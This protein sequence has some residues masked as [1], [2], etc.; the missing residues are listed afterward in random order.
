[1]SKDANPPEL[2]VMFKPE[3]EISLNAQFEL[4]SAKLSRAKLRPLTKI[5]QRKELRLEPIFKAQKPVIEMAESAQ[6][7]FSELKFDPKSFISVQSDEDLQAIAA[8]LREQDAVEAA[9]VKPAA[10]LADAKDWATPDF[11]ANQGYL[12]PA[13]QGIDAHF[14]WRMAGGRGEGIE[15]CDVEQGF[16][17][18]HEDLQRNFGGLIGGNNR[19]SS[20]DHGTA[21]LGV[22]GADDNGKGVTGICHNAKIKAISHNG[23]GTAQAIIDAAD[24][25]KAGDIILIEVH[26]P[27][28]AHNPENGSQDAFI[29]IEWWPD[30]FAAIVYATSRGILVVE[31]AGN[32]SEDFDAEI[33]N[34][35][36]DGFPASWRNPLNPKNP[37]SGAVI[38][39]AGSP[40]SWSDRTIL[41]FSN[42]GSRV[43][44]QGWG[45][46]VATTGYGGMQGD[47]VLQIDPFDGYKAANN[48][49]EV[50]NSYFSGMTMSHVRSA[51]W[52]G[53]NNKIYLF[54]PPRGRKKAQ[55]TRIDAATMAEDP[56]YPKDIEGNWPGLPSD[57]ERGIDAALWNSKSNKIYFFKGSQYVR[58]NPN[59]SWNVES[60]YPKPIAGNWPGLPAHFNTG[61]DAAVYNAKNDK[62]YL[63][64]DSQYVRIDPDN[65][66]Q[67]DMGYPKPIAGN[68]SAFPRAFEQG[69][70][71]AV[72]HPDL[73][74][75]YIF[76]GEDVLYTAGFNGT[77]SASPIVTGALACI[78]SRLK[79][80]GKPLLTPQ[81]AINL[82]RST[83]SPQM[84][85]SG[86][87]ETDAPSNW[88]GVNA[89]FGAGFGAALWNGKSDRIYFFR[90]SQFVR[91]NP[92]DN[93]NVEAGYPKAIDGNWPGLADDF[94]SNINAA[95][96]SDTNKKVYLFKG[97]E[98][99]RIDP[100]N[101]WNMDAGY[102]KPIAGNWPGFPTEFTQGVDAAIWNPKN[103]KVYFF[104][105]DEYIRVNPNNS[106]QVDPN[107][108]KPI[109]GNWPNLNSNFED[110]LNAALWSGTNDKIYFFKGEDYVRIDPDND[111]RMDNGY[112]RVIARQ[113][114]G[115]RPDLREVFEQLDLDS[116]W[117]GFP[118]NFGQNVDAALYSKRNNRVYIFQGSQ[119]LRV[120]PNNG[121]EVDRGYP[122]N[123][124]GNWPGF[125]S[126]FAQGVD[127]AF[128]SKKNSRIYFFKN[129]EYIRVNPNNGWRVDAG[130]PKPIAGNWP[131]FP[132]HFAEGVDAAIWTE[133]NDRVYFFKDNEYIRVN[134]NDDWQVERNYPRTIAGNWRGLPSSFN[135]GI[136]LALWNDKSDK[137]YFFA[138][139]EYVRINPNAGWRVEAGYPKPIIS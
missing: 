86:A 6:V 40:A 41:G 116:N 4:Q 130:Y 23:L 91:I 98:Y 77:S 57:F 97:S 20:I 22:L 108:P 138:G 53:T 101:G 89:T 12:N 112:P 68:W 113:R 29:A 83:G 74:K 43:D 118:N 42:W 107:Y 128:W 15:V 48:D 123:I 85:F 122:R 79:T 106:W 37:S 54:D 8:N 5:L 31:A 82:M 18:D 71:A 80:R 46:S 59:A 102:P 120:N 14:A 16:N 124:A 133:K 110:N 105:D 3:A 95:F 50:P 84:R 9:Y 21:V 81:G 111:W 36:S 76:K 126:H 134:P 104:R 47:Q 65:S 115:N 55:Y 11:T 131:G 73:K 87:Q 139:N 137:I 25:L 61:I 135:S 88:K 13:P 28:P 100:F 32:G 17:F 92:A 10:E 33:Y 117:P 1:M 72:Y 27:G 125:P 66:W 63:F 64:K 2:V 114:I 119:Y 69:V 109:D 127:A 38:V 51:L 90:G 56:N 103:N 49:P 94:K 62:V 75:M 7:I 39:G 44:V 52:S 26:R 60:G 121:W 67:V 24:S 93:W 58:I 70:E 30:D 99:V 35:P 34:R 19:T 45:N 96:W 132:A 136:D 129:D 78:Q